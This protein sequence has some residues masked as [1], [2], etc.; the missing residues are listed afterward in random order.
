MTPRTK[1]DTRCPAGVDHCRAEALDGDQRL[2]RR[3]RPAAADSP[4]SERNRATDFACRDQNT[5]RRRVSTTAD[6]GSS[7]ERHR[8]E[9]TRS[10]RTTQLSRSGAPAATDMT[11]IRS[12]AIWLAR[13]CWNFRDTEELRQRRA[14]VSTSPGISLVATL[15][16][17]KLSGFDRHLRDHRR[18]A[19]GD[20]VGRRP[21]S[22]NDRLAKHKPVNDRVLSVPYSSSHWREVRTCSAGLRL[23]ASRCCDDNLNPLRG[24]S[25]KW[26]FH[27]AAVSPRAPICLR[28]R[29]PVDFAGLL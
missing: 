17:E 22:D 19:P 16:L 7:C 18:T 21:K 3:Q 13:Q 9:V 10:R 1:G 29:W 28:P 4:G 27:S 8:P 11:A 26:C 2:R 5:R 24:V 6:L 14:V 23:D 20:N 15:V 25:A 12:Q